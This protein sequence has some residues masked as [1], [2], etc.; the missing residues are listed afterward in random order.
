VALTSTSFKDVRTV[1][2]DA[3]QLLQQAY[4]AFN[5]RK[6]DAALAPMC[7]D[8]V[9]PNGMEG[10]VVHGHSGIPEYW[11]RQWSL[12]DPDVQPLSIRQQDGRFD[13]EVR[14]LVIVEAA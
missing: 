14:Q 3:E 11:T 4:A 6:I 9:W 8:V 10:G 5:A 13:V 12:I 1:N 2:Q 7:P